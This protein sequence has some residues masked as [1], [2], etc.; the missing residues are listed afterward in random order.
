MKF[1]VNLQWLRLHDVCMKCFFFVSFGYVFKSVCFFKRFFT[2]KHCAIQIKARERFMHGI[3]FFVLFLFWKSACKQP[4]VVVVNLRLYVFVARSVFNSRVWLTVPQ[5]P[6][7]THQSPKD[8]IIDP[9][10]NVI[11][12]CEAKGKP[13]PRWDYFYCI[14]LNMYEL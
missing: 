10:E 12:H 5:P 9:R 3:K 1:A 2:N 8:Y 11:I 7:I 4:R 14:V 13:H 6:T